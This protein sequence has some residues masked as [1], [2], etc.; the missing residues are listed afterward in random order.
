MH[1]TLTQILAT[2]T[3]WLKQQLFLVFLYLF[4]ATD[5]KMIYKPSGDFT[6]T[7]FE[8]TLFHLQIQTSICMTNIKI[9]N[10]FKQFIRIIVLP[11]NLVMEINI[12]STILWIQRLHR[13][14]SWSITAE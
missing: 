3:S 7:A 13:N 6:L 12:E 9:K 1:K 5:I 2:L 11:V 8:S 4:H 14:S 10:Q